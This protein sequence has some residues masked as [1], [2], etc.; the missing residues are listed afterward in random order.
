MK[1]L[2]KCLVCGNVAELE[3]TGVGKL[4]C[5]GKEMNELKVNTT[6]GAH[7]KHIPVIEKQGNGYLI[8]VGSVAHPMTVEHYIV[9]VE[10]VF[11]NG[12]LE[13]KYLTPNDKPEVFFDNVESNFIVREYCNLHGL[14][15]NKI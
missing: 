2:Y 3:L 1:N 12:K 10:L 8:K 6:D 7:E 15:E 13:R 9:W 5:C 14:W 4:V 11:D